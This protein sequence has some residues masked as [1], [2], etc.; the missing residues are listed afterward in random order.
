M[1]SVN[2]G[3]G[4]QPESEDETIRTKIRT[5]HLT[6]GWRAGQFGGRVGQEDAPGLNPEVSTRAQWKCGA[7]VEGLGGGVVEDV[8]EGGRGEDGAV[9]VAEVEEETGL[10]GGVFGAKGAAV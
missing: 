10:D 9:V 8:V 4:V 1:V 3:I 7:V 2:G 5:P 6:D